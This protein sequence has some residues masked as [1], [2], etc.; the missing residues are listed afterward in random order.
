M[1]DHPP[2]E[3]DKWEKE[4]SFKERELLLKEG[5]LDLKK[6]EHSVSGW[7][8]PVVVAILAATVAALGNALVSMTNGKLQRELEDQKSE[9]ARILEMIKTGDPDKAAEN[10]KFLLDAGLISN[11]EIAAK[12]GTFLSKRQPGSGP[13]LP[14]ATGFESNTLAERIAAIKPKDSSTVPHVQYSIANH[15]L[16]DQKGVPVSIVEAPGKGT[17]LIE[18]KAIVLHFTATDSVEGT[19]AFM[20]SAQAK[21]STHLVIDRDGK[22]TQ[23][24]PFDISA[25]HAGQSTWK[26]LTGLNKYSIAIDLVNA[27]QLKKSGDQ[28]VSWNGKPYAES[29]VFLNTNGETGEVTGWHKYTDKQIESA[30]QVIYALSSAYSTIDSILGH[31]DI[32]P[33]RKTDPGPALPMELL[34]QELFL[35][36]GSAGLTIQS[37]GP[38]NAGR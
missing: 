15:V 8:S 18:A 14:A 6:K 1:S 38:A 34:R 31:S 12:L 35:A 3:R 30:K 37:S 7:K 29:E 19:L 20:A 16:L 4:L 25:W 2:S 26:G 24:V 5:E 28:W 11:P 10:L 36:R 13:T 9:Q 33:G 27:G 21:A 32:S 23:L 17:G 22:V